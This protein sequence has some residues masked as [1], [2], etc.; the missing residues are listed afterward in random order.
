M[1]GL[2]RFTLKQTVFINVV[3]VL[4]MVVGIFSMT[5]LPVERYPNVHMGKVII[6]GFLP[7][8]SPSDVEALV[9]K[10]IEDALDDLENVEYIRSRSFREQSSIMV[11]FIDDIDYAKGYDELRFRVLSI[12][13][14]LPEEMDPPVFTEINVSEWLPVIRVCLV[15][16]RAN[17]ALAM[18]ADE[19]KV[20][21]R[22]I[23]GVNEVEIE[24]E[25]T[26][27]FHVN[28]D[29]GKLVRFK[30][31]FDDVARALADANISIPAGDFSSNN[32]EYVI[33]VDE[34]FRTREDIS[35]TI[36]RMDGDGSFVTVGDVMSDAR[37][38]YR[39]PKVITSING[40]NAV[41]LKI[42]K[43]VDGNAVTIAEDVEAV[44]ASFKDA[45]EREGVKLVLTNDQRLHIDEAIT[46]LGLNLLVGI[47]LVFIVIYLVMGFRNA[48]LT[49]IG[50]PFAFLVTMIIMKLTGNSLNQITLFSFV[51]VSGIIV[52]DAIVVVENIFRHVQEGKPLKE[53]VVDGTAEV[54]LPVVSATATTVAA[55]LPMLIMSGSTGEFFAQV[56]KA[57]TFALI[58]SLIECL[59]ILP[60]HFL[61]W[62]GAKILAKDSARHTREPV[63]MQPVR[64]WTDKLLAVVMRFR[65]T[66]LTVVF[67]AFV[68]AIFILVVS[69]SG[70]IPLI[71]I[72]FFPDD[73]SLY[74]IELEGPVATPIELTSDKLKRISVFVEKMGPGMSKSATAFAG[75]YQNEDYEMVH[76]SNLGNIVVELPAK[77]KQI[78]ADAPE[79]DPGTHL[80]FMRKALEHFAGAGWSLRVRPEKDGPPTGKDL[81]IRI[82][83]SDHASVQG[84]TTAI[85]GFINGNDKLGPHLV[86]LTTDDGTPNRIFRFNPI[87]ERIME[88]GLTPKQ[89]ALLSGSVL[90]GRFVGE[91]RL[92]DEDV[93]LRLKIDP[94]F[95]TTPED[96]L[97]VPVLEHNE[98]PVR[99][100]DICKVSIYMEP[101][102]FNRFMSQRAVTITA[103][104]K[105]GSRLSSTT[106]VSLVKTFYETV[107]SEYPGATINFSGEFESTRKSYTSLVYAFLTAILII[108]LIL[109]TQF[110]SYAQPVIILSA[111][112][113][114]LTGVILGTFFS[115]TIFTVNSFIATVGVTGVVVNDS[116]VLLDFMN[117]L[118]KGGMSRKDALREGVRIRLRPI[119]LTT[120][121]TTLGLLPMAIGF[122]S[123]S[124][125]WGAMASTF[126]TGLCT[127]TF[128]TLFIIPIEWDLLMGFFEWKEKRKAQRSTI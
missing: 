23:A 5:D 98:S 13:N 110:Q 101:G 66:S 96:A 52:D 118:Y 115:Q 89:V 20:P 83:G 33:V 36:V 123:Y 58:A 81:N 28:L 116:L 49:T 86:N 60:A 37:V 78:F 102:Q 15:G 88:Y 69:I 17:R 99:L 119:L 44:V 65:F 124:L 51:L 6:T 74:Y 112:V 109:A 27:E 38:S 35:D 80:E 76:G 68:V 22:K 9:T 57:V 122:P 26:R 14:D 95:L 12:Q 117:K 54:F 1:K 72:K 62:P 63:F 56:P 4:L 31:T 107:R 3:F 50:V 108:Y 82:L 106:A 64:R 32:G 87:N 125:V 30:L 53:A 42:I 73:Y 47:A 19:I 103:N 39:D 128:L 126:V 92:A 113:F 104:I 46:T 34:R 55:F 77:D 127:A 111:V 93:D 11:K 94:E 43:S 90:D 91:F 48:M 121:T 85:M 7:G 105:S 16:D 97:T 114:S 70:K 61:D 67:G 2:M 100:G 45:L 75:F 8:A 71:K 29:P 24:G 79:N 40:H 84:L 10:K 120:L 21:L 41:T 25:Y 59:I 18:M